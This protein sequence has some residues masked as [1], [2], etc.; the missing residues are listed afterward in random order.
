MCNVFGQ[1]LSSMASATRLPILIQYT[2]LTH[3]WVRLA[4]HMLILQVYDCASICTA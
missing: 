1:V 2:Y 3:V 4:V